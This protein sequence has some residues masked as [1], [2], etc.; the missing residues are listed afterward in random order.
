[1]WHRENNFTA[2]LTAQV[3]FRVPLNTVGS[4]ALLS[5]ECWLDWSGPNALQVIFLV[6]SKGIASIWAH[7]N[8]LYGE[9]R[10]I[11]VV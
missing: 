11:P 4:L 8:F 2:N 1:M 3:I 9:I 5:Y 6:L 10:L 7:Q